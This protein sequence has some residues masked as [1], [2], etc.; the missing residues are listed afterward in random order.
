MN[1]ALYIAATGLQTH[2]SNVDNVANNLANINTPGFKRTTA[3]FH[4]V[5]RVSALTPAADGTA[6]GAPSPLGVRIANTVKDFA[7]GDLRPTGSNMD[8]AIRGEGFIE[9]QLPDGTPA[10]SR[11]G[12]MLIDKNGLLSTVEGYALRPAIHIGRDISNLV[13]SPDGSI[14]GTDA[15]G[16]QTPTLGRIEVMNFANASG[17][18]AMGDRL[19]R[20]SES[21]GEAV[22]AKLG[23]SNGPSLVQGFVEASNVRL[24]DEMVTL[25]VAQRAYE[26]N[27]KVIQT[28]D[29]MASMSNNLRR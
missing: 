21:S 29:E 14:R 26:M 4:D 27:V 17:L 6:T 5:M 7:A 13:I 20:S 18:Q 16:R 9:V 22:P 2:Q 12:P 3:N 1:D 11:G 28:A 15:N 25:M 24:V 8:L 23:E 10:F 19:Y